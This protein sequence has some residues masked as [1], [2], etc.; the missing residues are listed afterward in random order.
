MLS[1][2]QVYEAYETDDGARYLVD[3]LWPRGIKKEKLVMNAWLKNIAPSGDLRRWFGHDTHKWQE[4]KRRYHA[5]LDEN[6]DVWKPLVEALK[7][8]KVTLLYAARDRE[9]NNALA[10]KLYLDKQ[11]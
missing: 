2:K 7:Q 1:I 9:H 5:E 10:L 4:F 8:G 11:T 3:R 6:P